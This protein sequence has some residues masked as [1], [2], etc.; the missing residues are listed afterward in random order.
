MTEKIYRSSSGDVHY[1]LSDT[2][3]KDIPTLFF[4]HGLTA[5]HELFRS[6]TEQVNRCIEDL[7]QTIS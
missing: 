1:W 7:L 2:V 3:R 4:M 5:S 6:Q